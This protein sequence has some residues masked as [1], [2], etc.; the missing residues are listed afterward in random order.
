[1]HSDSASSQA[2]TATFEIISTS[3]KRWLERLGHSLS[4]ALRSFRSPELPPEINQKD[5]GYPSTLTAR[6]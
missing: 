5:L 4:L 2:S 3:V 1:M 6:F